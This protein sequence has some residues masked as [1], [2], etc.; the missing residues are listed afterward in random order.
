MALTNF[1]T[2]RN[3]ISQTTPV[4]VNLTFFPQLI[5]KLKSK[6]YQL[7]RGTFPQSDILIV[8]TV[9]VYLRLDYDP[10]DNLVAEAKAALKQQGCLKYLDHYLHLLPTTNFIRISND[11]SIKIGAGRIRGFA[12]K[13]IRTR[14]FHLSLDA[15]L[16]WLVQNNK[17]STYWIKSYTV[18][19]KRFQVTVDTYQQTSRAVRK[20]HMSSREFSAKY[21]TCFALFFDVNIATQLSN[22]YNIINNIK[23][24]LTG[25]TL[26]DLTGSIVDL[27][28]WYWDGN[29]EI[30]ENKLSKPLN[31]NKTQQSANPPDQNK[32]GFVPKNI[33]L[34]RIKVNQNFIEVSDFT[35]FILNLLKAN[36]KV[37]LTLSFSLQN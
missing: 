37:S 17:D 6:F 16:A 11:N 4:S 25:Y 22:N 24:N 18:T 8:F 27:L 26:S 32:S 23:Y 36:D 29:S 2:G 33:N 12:R 10:G 9:L 19:M 13:Y 35:N 21:S 30:T 5:Q 31:D 28:N 1:S 7:G 15:I 14:A 3:F 20:I 34:G